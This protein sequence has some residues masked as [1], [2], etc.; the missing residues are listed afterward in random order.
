MVVVMAT[1]NLSDAADSSI[2]D[3][4]LE[5]AATKIFLPSVYARGTFSSL[6]AQMGL[7]EQ[8]LEIIASA[9]PKNEYYLVS[10]QGCRKFSFALGP[11][12]LAFVGASDKESVA[13]IK[14]LQRQ[15]GDQWQ[16]EWVKTKG[17]SLHGDMEHAHAV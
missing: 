7:N 14:E 6:Y 11:V 10:E 5:A 17:I 8:Q 15:Y 9:Q 13:R 2:F 3:V 12:A 4:I 1:Q 16:D